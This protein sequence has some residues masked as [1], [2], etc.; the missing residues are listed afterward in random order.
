MESLEEE[1]EDWEE[2]LAIAQ[3]GDSGEE[4]F[5]LELSWFLGEALEQIIRRLEWLRSKAEEGSDVEK[6]ISRFL[7]L[8]VK[9]EEEE[10][11]EKKNLN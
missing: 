1:L 4:K 6:E 5:P 11:E 2:E 8:A 9:D 3:E 7:R 10:E